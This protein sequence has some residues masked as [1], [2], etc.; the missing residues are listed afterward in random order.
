MTMQ[1]LRPLMVAH[2][3]PGV[4]SESSLQ[5]IVLIMDE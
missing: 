1:R 2:M 3:P 5:L 4:L